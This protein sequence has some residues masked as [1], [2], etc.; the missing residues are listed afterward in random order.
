MILLNTG[1]IDLKKKRTCLER[2]VYCQQNKTSSVPARYGGVAG[3]FYM[4]TS[5][6]RNLSGHHIVN[7]L[8]ATVHEAILIMR[9]S[10]K[11]GEDFLLL[12]LLIPEIDLD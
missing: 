9:E 12:G 11:C 7:A 1:L 10:I 4:I 2:C 5:D 3:L 6:S 8:E